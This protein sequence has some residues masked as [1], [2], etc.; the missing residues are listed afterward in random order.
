MQSET[1]KASDGS[2]ISAKDPART[3]AV[4]SATVAP[5]GHENLDT[6][7]FDNV[8]PE[9]EEG[10][11]APFLNL[12]MDPSLISGWNGQDFGDPNWDWC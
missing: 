11:P 9:T 4:G 3:P 6:T 2:P 12:V 8:I 10:L 1:N 5:Y 7:T